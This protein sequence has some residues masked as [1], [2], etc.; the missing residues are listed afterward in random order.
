M[1]L[2]AETAREINL[3][4]FF[5]KLKSMLRKFSI[6]LFVV[7]AISSCKYQNVVFG[8]A[9]KLKVDRA[10][11]NHYPVAEADV[12]SFASCCWLNNGNIFLNRAIENPDGTQI[13]ISVSESML[14]SEFREAQKLFSF[15]KI[16]QEKSFSNSKQKIDCYLI[17]NGNYFIVRNVWNELKGGLLIIYDQVTTSESK[18][19][20][21]Y[22]DVENHLHKSVH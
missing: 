11:I 5:F 17:H 14:Q 13:Y 1:L 12:D 8:R 6:L 19:V 2:Q 15:F 10:S 3:A 4:G 7:L 21:M 9:S 16:I 22:A 18:A 20:M